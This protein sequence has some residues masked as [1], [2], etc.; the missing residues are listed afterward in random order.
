MVNQSLLA[1]FMGQWLLDT[2]SPDPSVQPPQA[3]ATTYRVRMEGSN[4]IF[5]SQWVDATGCK[6][7][8]ALAGVPD[9]QDRAYQNSMLADTLCLTLR[10]P[11]EIH[12]VIKKRDKMI[13]FARRKLL[14]E[15]RVRIEQTIWRNDGTEIKTQSEYVRPTHDMDYARSQ[16]AGD[17]KDDSEFESEKTSQRRRTKSARK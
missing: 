15:D 5:E 13:S 1:K 9:G 6:H 16:A 2:T 8:F 17:A 4:V 3:V 10:E 7:A 11:D 12:T 14:G